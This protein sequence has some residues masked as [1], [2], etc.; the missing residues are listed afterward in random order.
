MPAS[1]YTLC[2]ITVPHTG[3]HF[4]EQLLDQIGLHS[5][6]KVYMGKHWDPY[7]SIL[8][9][10]PKL[11]ITARDPYLTA[12]R[13]IANGDLIE[14]VALA[15]DN[16]I[17]NLY[18]VDYYLLDIGCREADRLKHAC[19]LARF[20]DI[21][22]DLHMEKLV[23]FVKAW[24]PVHTTEEEAARGMLA[25]GTEHNKAKY[26]ESGK[27]PEGYDW[28]VLDNAVEWYKSLSTNDY[29]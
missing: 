7:P 2:I 9:E 23:P 16:C 26:L 20:L 8:P 18:N 6:D 28:S 29:V 25:E 15:F 17:S 11:L 13:Y 22:P 10:E 14:P 1:K 27:L 19:D 21:D 12:L 4:A 5:L 24:K 3:T